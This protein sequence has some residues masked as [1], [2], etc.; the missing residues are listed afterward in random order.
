MLY[1]S[2]KITPG[3]SHNLKITLALDNTMQ[4][5]VSNKVLIDNLSILTELGQFTDSELYSTSLDEPHST[6]S[7]W[8]LK[9]EILVGK[10]LLDSAYNMYK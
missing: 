8:T 2:F 3:A 9:S 1:D 5:Q 4:D 7:H 10:Y 6:T